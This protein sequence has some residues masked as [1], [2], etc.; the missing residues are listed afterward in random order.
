M[1][2]WR[3]SASR[4]D[5]WDARHC[6]G[7]RRDKRTPTTVAGGVEAELKGTAKANAAMRRIKEYQDRAAAKGTKRT[8]TSQEEGHQ[9]HEPETDSSD[10][11]RCT[12]F[13]FEWQRQRSASAELEQQCSTTRMSDQ[14]GGDSGKEA[15]K[16][17]KA[18]EEHSEDPERDDGKWMRTEETSGRLEKKR[19]RAG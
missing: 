18:E 9:Q 19:R 1:R 7:E 14:E 2:T 8:K 16:K 13:E 15:T 11:R 10:G 3:S 12:S 6:F 4:R 17:R 5:V